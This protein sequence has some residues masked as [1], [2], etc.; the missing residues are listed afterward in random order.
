MLSACRGITGGS[1][2]A[3]LPFQVEGTWEFVR[4]GNKIL[5]KGFQY[6]PLSNV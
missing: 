2:C 1:L 5:V 3:E 4:R 6:H